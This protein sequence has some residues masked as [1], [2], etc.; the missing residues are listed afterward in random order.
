MWGNAQFSEIVTRSAELCALGIEAIGVSIL[1]LFS[2]WTVLRGVATLWQQRSTEA[3]LRDCRQQLGR[4]ILIGLEFL[5]AADIIHTVAV[6]LTYET[7]TVLGLI[8]LIRTFLSFM[9]ELELTGRWP[10]QTD[11]QGPEERPTAAP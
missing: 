6:E 7:V 4:G 9:L 3:A 5:V 10:W 1:A 8:V 2:A 11:N